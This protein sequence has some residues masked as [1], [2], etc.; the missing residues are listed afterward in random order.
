MGQ[1]LAQMWTNKYSK[2]ILIKYLKKKLKMKQMSSFRH[3]SFEPSKNVHCLDIYL[4]FKTNKDR[5]D[6]SVTSQ[7]CREQELQTYQSLT[8]Y[9]CKKYIFKHVSIIIFSLSLI[10]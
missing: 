1:I 2:K 6:L 8:L 5:N 9:F 7:I 3:C 10:W 4:N